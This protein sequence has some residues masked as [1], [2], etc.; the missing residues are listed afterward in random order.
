MKAGSLIRLHVEAR[1]GKGDWERRGLRDDQQH[2]KEK[3][4]G[5]AGQE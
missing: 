2:H 3:K 5:K 1:E 4:S